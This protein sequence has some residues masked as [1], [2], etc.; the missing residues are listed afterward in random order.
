MFPSFRLTST[1]SL[2]TP[3]LV[4]SIKRRKIVNS[5]NGDALDDTTNVTWAGVTLPGVQIIEVN[6]AADLTSSDSGV[7]SNGTG[8]S[9]G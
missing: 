4:K 3:V 5:G 1:P 7:S 9:E 8:R 2:T 6:G